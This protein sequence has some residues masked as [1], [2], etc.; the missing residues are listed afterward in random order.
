MIIFATHEIHQAAWIA[1]YSVTG[2]PVGSEI[3]AQPPPFWR[4]T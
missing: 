3:P 4:R 1:K 2:K